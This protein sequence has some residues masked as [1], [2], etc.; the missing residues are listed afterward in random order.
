MILFTLSQNKVWLVRNCYYSFLL[1]IILLAG[2]F[3]GGSLYIF[4]FDKELV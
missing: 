1:I 3:D 2:I 4:N